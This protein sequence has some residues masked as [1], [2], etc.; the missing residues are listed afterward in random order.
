MQCSSRSFFF[1]FYFCV[2]ESFCQIWPK[3][4]WLDCDIPAEMSFRARRSRPRP[5]GTNTNTQSK[6]I[7]QPIPLRKGGVYVSVWSGRGGWHS[8]CLQPRWRCRLFS[9]HSWRSPPASLSYSSLEHSASSHAHTQ[10]S[11]V[12]LQSIKHNQ[13]L[14]KWLISETQCVVRWLT[15]GG[16]MWLTSWLY[17]RKT[18][19]LRS[20]LRMGW[21]AMRHRKTSCM[22]TVFLKMA[23]YSLAQ[24]SG[25]GN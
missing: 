21:A 16:V 11:G 6:H 23:R 1:F 8:P 24:W 25:G 18:W 10:M 9:P 12:E 3:R 22:A 15:V 19:K 4:L 13:T 2:S 17:S 5:A 14:S 7:R 20:F